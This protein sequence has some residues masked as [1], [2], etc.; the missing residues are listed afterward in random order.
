MY[1]L[2]GAFVIILA[3]TNIY[4]IYNIYNGDTPGTLHDTFNW[5]KIFRVF[6]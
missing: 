2:L 3:C 4:I 1:T 5:A 6:Y